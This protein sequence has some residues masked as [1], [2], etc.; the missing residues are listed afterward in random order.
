MLDTGRC[1]LAETDRDTKRLKQI[2]LA[3]SSILLLED[4]VMLLQPS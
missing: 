3:I 1:S 4:P 2:V